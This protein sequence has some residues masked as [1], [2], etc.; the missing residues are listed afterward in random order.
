MVPL[1]FNASF[2]LTIANSDWLSA[3]RLRPHNPL[4]PE[5]GSDFA[6]GVGVYWQQKSH[7]D[8]WQIF[9]AFTPNKI[10]L[11]SLLG[12]WTQQELSGYFTVTLVSAEEGA[13]GA[14]VRLTCRSELL[15]VWNMAATETQL[16]LSVGLIGKCWFLFCLFFM[17]SCSQDRLLPKTRWVSHD[18]SVT[19]EV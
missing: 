1:S 11:A 7:C 9:N 16:M 5:K 13:R 6:Q 2:L 18:T 3:A 8:H 15:Q 10:C 14:S 17:L 12:V 19:L 4:V